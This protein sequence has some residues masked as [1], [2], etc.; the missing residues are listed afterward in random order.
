MLNIRLFKINYYLFIFI[1]FAFFVFNFLIFYSQ[2]CYAEEYPKLTG[3]VV[4][5]LNVLKDSQREILENLLAKYEENT[6]NQMVVCFIKTT[7][8]L[9]IEQYSIN[10][11]ER[12]KIG[13][14]GKD[15]GIILLFAMKDRSMRIDVGYGLEPYL[16]DSEAKLIIEK[17]LV[18]NFKKEKY[19]EGVKDAIYY[20]EKETSGIEYLKTKFIGHELE[21]KYI[22]IIMI[23]LFILGM[24]IFIVFAILIEKNKKIK[25]YFIYI[26]A[27]ILIY[28]VL[29][30]FYKIKGLNSDTI[31]LLFFSGFCSGLII[32]SIFWAITD[33]SKSSTS[34]SSS[35]RDSFS[36]SSSTSYSSSS[37]DSSSS[38]SGGGG[39]F[40]GGGASGKW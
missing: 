10:L 25:Y 26:V 30:K 20:I 16:T 34:Y 22:N 38:F 28:I 27:I 36:S 31:F 23:I 5:T 39:S 8:P 15:N 24:G 14:K 35:E 37:N 13:Y 12:W 32:T 1:L 40:G 6:G 18:P 9:Q 29:T 11:A 33:K 4:D 7:Y 3:R 21:K 19:F 17:V 2:N